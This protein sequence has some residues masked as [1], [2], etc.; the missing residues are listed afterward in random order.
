MSVRAKRPKFGWFETVRKD[1]ASGK[2]R[3]IQIKMV[4]GK[5]VESHWLDIKHG[6]SSLSV[7]RIPNDTGYM[8][9]YESD[10][11]SHRFYLGSHKDSKEFADQVKKYIEENNLS[12]KEIQ[13]LSLDQFYDPYSKSI[14]KNREQEKTYYWIREILSNNHETEYTQLYYD[15][16]NELGYNLQGTHEEQENFI[17]N[18]LNSYEPEIVVNLRPSECKDCKNTNCRE[19]GSKDF[20]INCPYFK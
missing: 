17:V 5:E 7:E 1:S 13:R 11:E 14:F 2:M 20:M 19:S 10:H 3:P 9:F 15:K 6:V 16:W 8:I 4:N 18:F 12:H